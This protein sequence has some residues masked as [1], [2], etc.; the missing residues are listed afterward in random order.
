M[1]RKGTDR[2][3]N[4]VMARHFCKPIAVYTS[5]ILSW[6]PTLRYM[7]VQYMDFYVEGAKL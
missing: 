6:H 7:Q 2:I 1:H 5:Y 4:D 3:C